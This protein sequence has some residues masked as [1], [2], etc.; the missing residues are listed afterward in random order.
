M[1]VG[2]GSSLQ[3]G[4]FTSPLEPELKESSFDGLIPSAVFVPKR[5]HNKPHSGSLC[6][7]IAKRVILMRQ[8][9]VNIA[10]RGLQGRHRTMFM[11]RHA[12]SGPKLTPDS[13][14]YVKS[15]RGEELPHS[16]NEL[17]CLLWIWNRLQTKST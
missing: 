9:F 15:S 3:M 2:N 7:N 17:P 13:L 14:S 10:K 5:V 1:T 16:I 12:S 8:Y 4:E 6:I 11:A